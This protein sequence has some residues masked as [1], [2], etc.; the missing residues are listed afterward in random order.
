MPL[1]IVNASGSAINTEDNADALIQ[2]WYSG[3]MGGKAL[4]DILLGRISPSGK[5]PVTFYGNAD[6]LPEFT[7]IL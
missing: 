7:V 3:A 5:L 4:A 1:I 2:A 6:L